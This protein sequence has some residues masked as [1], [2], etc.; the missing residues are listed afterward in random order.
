MKHD[1]SWLALSCLAAALTGSCSQA[2]ETLVSLR[3]AESRILAAETVW[4]TAT[5]LYAKDCGVTW[6]LSGTGCAG[7]ACGTISSDG[8]YTAPAHVPGRIDVAVRATSKADRTK[9]AS[10]AITVV[11]PDVVEWTWISGSDLRFAPGEFGTKGAPSPSNAPPGRRCAVRWLDFGDDFWLFGGEGRDPSGGDGYRNDL[12]KFDPS[13]LEW[14]WMAGSPDMDLPGIY[15]TKG[16]HSASN[17][18][19]ARIYAASATDLAGGLWLFGGSGPDSTG[20]PGELNDLWKF[21]PPSGDWTWMGGSNLRAAPGLYGTKGVPAPGNFPGARNSASAWS[22]P[23]GN[24]WLFGG[25]GY[26]AEGHE[27]L[28]NDLWFFDTTTLEWAWISGSDIVSQPG[29]YGTRGVPGLTNV[30]GARRW[31]TGGFDSTGNLWL[32][33]GDGYAAGAGPG[34]L[35]DLWKFDL[36]SG[37]W[38]WVSGSDALDRHADYGRKWMPLPSNLPGSRL[39]PA[40]WVD[41]DGTLWLF[42]GDGTVAADR[43]GALGDLWKFDPAISEWTWVSGSDSLG[44]SAVYGTR[45]QPDPLNVPGARYSALSWFD[46][47]GRYWLF[48][49]AGADSTGEY[50]YLNDLWRFERKN[51]ALSPH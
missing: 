47:Q 7:D 19:G 8:L 49:G 32:Y 10:A 41:S 38:T 33:G 35:N 5:V 27:F 23:N 15:G 42:G 17:S 14:T 31:A 22:D 18:P 34:H 21:D 16:M 13:T 51:Y 43:W 20:L 30:P 45:G 12:W 36:T 40:A 24:L 48:G 28:L 3:P 26:D 4:L 9:S 2:E 44:P 37:L 6:T 46:H 29:Q 50:G 25:I 1:R 11:E 39:E